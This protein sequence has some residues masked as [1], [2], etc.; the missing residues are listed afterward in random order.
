MGRSLERCPSFQH[1]AFCSSALWDSEILNMI[2]I[3]TTFI[4]LS[5]PITTFI[6]IIIVI[7]T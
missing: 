5:I 7:A 1:L 2:S 6:I 3:I 4:T